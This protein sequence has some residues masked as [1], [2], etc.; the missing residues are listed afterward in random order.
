MGAQEIG[1][2]LR[3]RRLEL[4][5]S[6]ET[7]SR[8][9]GVARSWLAKVESGTHRGA[10]VQKVV[11]LADVLGLTVTLAPRAASLR[12][13]ASARARTPAPSAS[14]PELPA[15]DPVSHAVRLRDVDDEDDPFQH[16]FG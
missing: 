9:A 1:A 12:S 11:D 10:E 5:L 16:L 8:S 2:Q 14:P 7:V 15:A 13:T 6:Q 3:A 4:R